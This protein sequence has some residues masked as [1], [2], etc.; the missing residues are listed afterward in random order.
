MVQAGVQRLLGQVQ[1]IKTALDGRPGVHAF[2][3]AIGDQ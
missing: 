3:V 2:G 1:L